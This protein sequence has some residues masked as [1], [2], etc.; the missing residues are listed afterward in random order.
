[1]RKTAVVL[2]VAATGALLNYAVPPFQNPDEPLH[3]A[4]ILR[5]ARGDAKAEADEAEIVRIMKRFNWWRLIGTRPPETEPAKL[6]E[7]PFLVQNY[8]VED[9]GALLN[10]VVAYHFAMAKIVRIFGGAE[11]KKGVLLSYFIVRLTSFLFFAA[12]IGVAYT[13]FRRFSGYLSYGFFFVLFLPQ[14]AVNSIG[15]NPDA[16]ILL[17]GSIFFSAAFGLVGGRVSAKEVLLRFAVI[18]ISAA[19]AV[20]LD[21][22]AFI[23]LPLGILVFIFYMTRKNYQDVI[24]WMLLLSIVF[25]LSVYFLS[26]AFPLKMESAVL[27]LKGMAARAKSSAGSIFSFDALNK[28]FITLFTD[29][30]FLRFGW[31]AFGG[32]R[33]VDWSWR[34]LVLLTS[35]GV[36][37]WSARLLWRKF[38]DRVK[39]INAEME[40]EK[41]GTETSAEP[42]ALVE[43]AT[44]RLWRIVLLS[45][46]AVGLQILV[47]RLAV[48]PD[49]MYAQGR[50]LFPFVIP[51]A[52]LFVLGLKN[53]FDN[54]GRRGIFGLKIILTA[55]FVFFAYVIVGLMIPAFQMTV[56][57]PFPGI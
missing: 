54:F 25:I 46:L 30:F 10:N 19:A 44:D 13:T 53:I 18:C 9:Y 8:E 48:A 1:M 11:E 2:L 35:L 5:F 26:L 50:Y 43:G 12:A 3:L 15:V 52:I 22:S 49:V 40:K 39:K 57:S 55:M 37:L 51:V 41:S 29:S 6:E 21:K 47:V 4:M 45:I 24:V 20:L 7:I 42:A 33:V 38:I 28:R 34:I 31:K 16:A 36:G 23:F 14:L 56:K 17:M 27:L 32:G